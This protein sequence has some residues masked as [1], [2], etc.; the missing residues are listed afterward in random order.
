MR[1]GI[2]SPSSKEKYKKLYMQSGTWSPKSKAKK[3]KQID[4]ASGGHVQGENFTGPGAQETKKK[5]R[6][7]TCNLGPGAN[8]IEKKKRN[9]TCNL[10]PGAQKTKK[11]D[12]KGTELENASWS[13]KRKEKQKVLKL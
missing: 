5:K 4:T 1:L 8:Q 7:C 3:R 12:I 11:K 6:T 10:G 13:P 2:R 9:C